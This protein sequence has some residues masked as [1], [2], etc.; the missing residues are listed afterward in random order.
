MMI[1]R[2]IR[3]TTPTTEAVMM[4]A[5]VFQGLV[6]SSAVLLRPGEVD[7]WLPRCVLTGAGNAFGD[8]EGGPVIGAC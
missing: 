1:V 4:V 8:V 6:S 7:V 3:T 2:M 5:V